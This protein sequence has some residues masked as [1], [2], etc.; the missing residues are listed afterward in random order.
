MIHDRIEFET[1]KDLL[2]PQSLPVLLQVAQILKNKPHIEL[3]EIH[4]H[5]DDVGDDMANI[6]L[7]EARAAS[8]RAYLI[9]QGIDGRR[10]IPRGFG[11][12]QPVAPN[13]SEANR[14]KNRRVE[15]RVV[16]QRPPGT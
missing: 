14:L 4:G 11:A 6:R 13:D 8:V 5:T 9:S 3:V 10:L 2:L 12:R 7:S 16:K 15:F 1:G